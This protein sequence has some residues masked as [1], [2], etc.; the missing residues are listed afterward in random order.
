MNIESS[1]IRYFRE[2][3]R[4]RSIRHASEVLNVAPSAISRQIVQLERMVGTALFERQSRGVA[5]TEAAEILAKFCRDFQSDV[6]RVQVEIDS[7]RGLQRGH[8]RIVTNE[9]LISYLLN[10]TIGSL[11]HRYPGITIDL[12]TAGTDAATSMVHDGDADVALVYNAMPDKRL[13]T[14][15]ELP[16]PLCLV[17]SPDHPIANLHAVELRRILEYPIGIPQKHFGIRRLFDAA[18]TASKLQFTPALVSNSIEALKGFA[19][20]GGG[21]TFLP[22]LP[23]RRELDRRVL[24]SIPI[25]EDT[26]QKSAHQ[27]CVQTNRRLPAAVQAFIQELKIETGRDE[28]E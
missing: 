5:P 7:L 23:T 3:Y 19:Q 10:R 21:A 27:V 12:I 22:K 8:I 16:D 13:T 2:V 20:F 26:F 9:G 4:L 11:R 14:V 6:E 28:T 25:L 17:V 24:I 1:P 15:V 18:V